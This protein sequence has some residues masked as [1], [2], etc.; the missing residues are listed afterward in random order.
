LFKKVSDVIAVIIN[1][2]EIKLKVFIRVGKLGALITL[3]QEGGYKIT[4]L[5]LHRLSQ[6]EVEHFFVAYKGVW[7]DYM[8]ILFF[9]HHDLSLI[10]FVD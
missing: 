10:L 9:H 2:I 5:K 4:G 1:G 8:V 7:E 3:I 6:V